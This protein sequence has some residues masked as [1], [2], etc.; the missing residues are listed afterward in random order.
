ME[1]EAAC[2]SARNLFGRIVRCPGYVTA[3]ESIEKCRKRSKQSGKFSGMSLIGPGGVGKSTVL[4]A[5]EAA[6]PPRKVADGTVIPVVRAKV[7]S[8]N[9]P[10]EMLREIIGA[11]GDIY[12]AGIKGGVGPHARRLTTVMKKARTEVLL[13]DECQNFMSFSNK[14][15]VRS[16]ASS[17]KNLMT[18]LNITLVVAGTEEA[19]GLVRGDSQLPSRMPLVVRLRP[20]NI[21]TAEGLNEFRG[22][23]AAL[24][25][26][27]YLPQTSRLH[28]M[29]IS[30]RIFYA[31]DGNFRIL[32]GL[33][34]TAVNVAVRE[35]FNRIDRTVLRMAFV[36]FF[37]LD[38][39]DASN[40]FSDCFV[41]RRLIREG[42][43][44]DYQA[45]M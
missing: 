23:L 14:N 1:E 19:L 21:E 20:F 44:F 4:E 29:E 27:I 3:F 11:F 33:L 36:E 8:S 31:C 28:E 12:L 7:S 13:L 32:T 2:I 24:E 39:K 30:Q 10:V 22:L 42:E 45:D 9:S 34:H 37:S 43:Y 5:Y 18:D 17:L 40:P 15:A 38:T 25:S 26:A 6:Y 35:G 16:A 41:P